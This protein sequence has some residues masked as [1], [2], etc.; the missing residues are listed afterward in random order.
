MSAGRKNKGSTLIEA[1]IALFI[2]VITIVTIATVI[3][4]TTK[5]R[6]SQE[7]VMEGVNRLET[8]KK[9]LICN[10]SYDEIKDVLKDNQGY[11]NSSITNNINSTEV[12]ILEQMESERNGYPCVKLQ[13]SEGQGGTMKI[14]ISY[15]YEE[16]NVIENVFYKGNYEKKQ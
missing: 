10:Y 12:N 8:V 14:I 9:L 1:M 4:S 5:S 6:L 13:G 15:F 16:D 7:E 3:T 11:F 2:A